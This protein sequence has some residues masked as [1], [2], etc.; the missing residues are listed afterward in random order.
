MAS[1][2]RWTGGTANRDWSAGQQ[3]IRV[4]DHERLKA[5]VRAYLADCRTHRALLAPK[6][7]PAVESALKAI[8]HHDGE[9]A[10]IREAYQRETAEAVARG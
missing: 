9:E 6:Y 7:H 10:F 8:Y 5:D 1:D 4:T 3:P 2:Q